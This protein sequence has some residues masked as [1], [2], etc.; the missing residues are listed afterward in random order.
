MS[1]L[2]R[3]V[4]VTGVSGYLAPHIVSAFEAQRRRVVGVDKV[5]ADDQTGPPVN[6]IDLAEADVL[7]RSG[8]L[9]DVD[10]VCHLGGVGDIYKAAEDPIGAFRDNAG[11]TLEVVRAAAKAGVRRVVVASSWHIYGEATQEPVDEGHPCRPRGAYALSKFSAEQLALQE[12]AELGLD[13]VALRLGTAYGPGMRPR[14]VVRA[15]IEA[16]AAGRALTVTDSRGVFRQLTHV[17]DLGSAFVTASDEQVPPGVYNAVSE[18]VVHIADLGEMIARRFGVGLVRASLRDETAS[19]RISSAKFRQYGWVERVSF[20][21]G[22]EEAIG[23]YGD[24][25]AA[26]K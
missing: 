8:L 16:A 11:A 26:A 9:G 19:F 20:A 17:S 24:R 4:M 6:V 18:E 12:G 2:G 13:V 22:L 25:P 7:A 1:V 10:V 3:T 5:A 21:A 15:M 23:L 14:A